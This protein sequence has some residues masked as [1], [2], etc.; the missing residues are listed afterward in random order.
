[1]KSIND[2]YIRWLRLFISAGFLF[3]LSACATGDSGYRGQWVEDGSVLHEIESGKIFPGFTYYYVGSVIAPDNFIAI[4]GGWHLRT[5][6]WN[7]IMMTPERLNGWL[8][9]YKQEH[10]VCEYRA[11]RILAP[12]G[13]LVGYWYSQ[14]FWN[15]IE[16]PAAGV[17]EVY[18]PFSGGGADCAEPTR[19]FIFH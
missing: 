5:R 14:N 4:A 2:R 11:G 12:D 18:Q 13:Q 9:W 16:Q 19:D 3:L 6:V 10:N 17:I 1:M 8:Q 15:I 7:K